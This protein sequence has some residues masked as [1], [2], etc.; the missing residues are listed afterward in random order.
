MPRR[1]FVN[2]GT[3]FAAILA[4]ADDTVLPKDIP[5][6]PKRPTREEW[7]AGMQRGGWSPRDVGQDEDEV[8][9]QS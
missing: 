8:H 9:A 6:L 3:R 1:Y 7:M 2:S 5:I 4:E